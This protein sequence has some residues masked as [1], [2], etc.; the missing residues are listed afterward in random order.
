MRSTRGGRREDRCRSS[1]W[2]ARTSRFRRLRGRLIVLTLQMCSDT[3]R[4]PSLS[5][6]VR[7][8]AALCTRARRHDDVSVVATLSRATLSA[9]EAAGHAS[10]L[11]DFG[12]TLVTDTCW[13]MLGEPLVPRG[14][15]LMTNS[16][17][18]AHYAPGLTGLSVRYGSLASC[19]QAATTGVAPAARP[20]W[21]GARPGGVRGAG[22]ARAYATSN[23]TNRAAGAARGLFRLLSRRH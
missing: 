19:V 10:A 22:A 14:G 12:A 5:S 20:R 8:L 21:L 23:A 13:C 11:R 18:Y 16:A 17:K 3:Q 9:A 15:A 1:R 2:A 6:Q 4:P 7:S